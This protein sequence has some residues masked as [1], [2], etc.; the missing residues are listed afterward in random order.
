M[1]NKKSKFLI[2]DKIKNTM[3]VKYRYLSILQK[4]LFHNRYI[5]SRKRLVFFYY[6]NQNSVSYKKTKNI[7][8]LSGENTAVN[9]KLLLSR[10]QINYSSVS[11]N[12]QNFKINSF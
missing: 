4:S 12:L 10:F 1:L 8:L 2:K 3:Y 9:K 11:N 5:N 6:L 7:C